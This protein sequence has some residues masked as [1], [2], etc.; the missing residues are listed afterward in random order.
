MN[1]EERRSKFTDEEQKILWILWNKIKEK[2]LKLK[3]S[4]SDLSEKT[5]IDRSYISMIER[6]QN[7]ITYLKLLRIGEILGENF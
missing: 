1:K 3:M 5:W 7:N 6:G 4:Q 2:R